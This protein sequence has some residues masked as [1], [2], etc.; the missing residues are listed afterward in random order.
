MK[1]TQTQRA[2]AM[3]VEPNLA[4]YQKM[5]STGGYDFEQM[6]DESID[7]YY[8]RVLDATWPETCKTSTTE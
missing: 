1:A 8:E 6:P 2:I 7:S 3:S 4:A 5:N